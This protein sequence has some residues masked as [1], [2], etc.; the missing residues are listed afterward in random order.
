MA[1]RLRSDA[2]LSPVTALYLLGR[3]VNLSGTALLPLFVTSRP[4]FL[5]DRFL[6]SAFA[7]GFRSRFTLDLHL[8]KR[9]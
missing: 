7:M 3:Q 5:R 9:M 4:Y 8:S 1:K 2:A 6:R